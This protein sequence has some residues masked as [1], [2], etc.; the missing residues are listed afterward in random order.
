NMPISYSGIN[1]EHAAVRNS[2]GVFDVSHM[3][4]FILKGDKA[5]GLIQK[6]TTNDASK[7][8]N[9]KAQYTCMPNEEGG[10]IDD[11]II[12]CIEENKTY[13]IVVNASN[14]EK[15]WNWLKKHNTENVEM[16][17][18][19]EKTCL[20]AIQGPNATKI[21]QSL[22]DVDILN[23]KYYSFV[24]GKFA[25]VEN[26]LISATGYTGSGGI[27]IYF[28]DKNDDANIIW[29][30]IFE[31]GTSKGL[32]PIGLA[33]RDTLR[34]EMGYCLY[35]N[36][37]DDTTSPLEAGLGWI[38]KLTKDFVG[39]EKI[40]ELKREGIQRKLVGLEMLE[41]GIPRHGYEIKDRE[42]LT[43]GHVTSGTQSPTLQKPIAM[44]Y[45]DIFYA[46]IDTMVYIKVRDKLLLSKVVKV[47]FE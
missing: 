28:E 4:E 34:L 27:E 12:Y 32:K 45:V 10:I 20:L 43:I 5:L 40:E 11:L 41:K 1:D 13:M 39:K 8:S 46:K 24:K 16:Q 47:P 35:G 31:E 26:V 33:A 14:I 19:S 23:L 18:I 2:V 3:G 22:T 37:I 17:N 36:D 15:D 42:G 30:K 9:G 21:V 6:V 38:T 25:G 7:I 44:G 29:D